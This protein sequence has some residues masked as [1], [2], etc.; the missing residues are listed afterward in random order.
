MSLKCA[1]CGAVWPDQLERE[2]GSTPR[3]QGY[4]SEPVCVRIRDDKRT[5]AGAVC[6][7]R[8][9]GSSAQE[10]EEL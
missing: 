8:L 2:W 4:G 6:R 5:G 7:G 9:T 3:S 1:R 10:T